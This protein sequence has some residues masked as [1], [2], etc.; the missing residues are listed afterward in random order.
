MKME[1]NK[2]P[3][4]VYIQRRSVYKAKGRPRVKWID[5][6][7]EILK[8]HG[9]SAALATYLAFERKLKLKPLRF[10]ASVDQNLYPPPGARQ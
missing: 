9:Y 10:I 5:N 3:V 4:K 1:N 7:N 8:K 2:L 6:I